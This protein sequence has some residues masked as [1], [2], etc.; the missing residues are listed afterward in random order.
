MGV[1]RDGILSK[2]KGIGSERDPDL[3]AGRATGPA[4]PGLRPPFLTADA[5]GM[6]WVFCRS[7]VTGR[8]MVGCPV[9]IGVGERGEA[10]VF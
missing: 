8:Q 4:Q 1:G 10:T 2:K 6:E 9:R 7:G 5:N 3:R